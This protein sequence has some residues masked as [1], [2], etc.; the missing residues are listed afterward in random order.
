M[1]A[2][3]FY[4]FRNCRTLQKLRVYIFRVCL[5]SPIPLNLFAMQ[6]SVAW[7]VI[8]LLLVG[9]LIGFCFGISGIVM[10]RASYGCGNGSFQSH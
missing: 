6:L 8:D 9:F 5:A 10:P 3:Y 4:L 7:I 1:L 2:L